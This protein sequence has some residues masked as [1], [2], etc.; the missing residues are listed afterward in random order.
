[1]ARSTRPLRRA[2]SRAVVAC[3]A[4]AMAASGALA[5]SAV[6]TI[7][8]SDAGLCYQT[9]RNPLGDDIASC[10]AALR[11][12]T[13]TQRDRRATLV[14]RGIVRNRLGRYDLAIADFTEAL[15][16]ADVLGEAYINRGNS[17]FLKSAYTDAIADYRAAL[18]GGFGQPEI[19]WYNIGL[20][21]KA[22]GNIPA[23][24]TAFIQATA[25]SPDFAPAREQLADLNAEDVRGD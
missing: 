10:D 23:A 22:S 15:Q 9:A 11:G 5:Q 8:S 17:H 2:L 6:T 13:L 12:D 4:L 25:A 14:N 7:G 3:S 20:A 16:G 24:R 21:E 1:M 19:A 18:S